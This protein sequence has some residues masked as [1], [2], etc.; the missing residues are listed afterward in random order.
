VVQA[1][2]LDSVFLEEHGYALQW[3]RRDPL[4]YSVLAER[5][6]ERTKL[7]RVADSDCRFFLTIIFSDDQ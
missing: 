1:A 5:G 6:G 2:Q 3:L 7:E 4:I